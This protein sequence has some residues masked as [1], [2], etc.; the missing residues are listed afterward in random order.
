M[1]PQSD[2]SS[3]SPFIYT[4]NGL[5]TFVTTAVILLR[6][7]VRGYMI[8]ALGWDDVLAVIALVSARA[9]LIL[10]SSIL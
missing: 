9:R 8:K 10:A 1:A 5:L 3:L 6:L 7:Y 4:I 2:S